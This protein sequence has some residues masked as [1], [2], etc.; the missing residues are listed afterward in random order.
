MKEN[1]CLLP[2]LSLSIGITGHRFIP[3]SEISRINA[4]LGKLLNEISRAAESITL[5]GRLVGLF[6]DQPTLRLVSCLSEGSDR[7]AAKLALANKYTLQAILPFPLGSPGHALDLQGKEKDES[8]QELRQLCGSSE[9]ILQLSPDIPVWLKGKNIWAN[10]EEASAFRQEAFLAASCEMLQFSDLLVAIW[11]GEPQPWQG[12]T[13][14]TILRAIRRGLPVCLISSIKDCPVRVITKEEDLFSAKP[15][16]QSVGDIIQQL[17]GLK[18]EALVSDFQWVKETLSSLE[19]KKPPLLARSWNFFQASLTRKSLK[20]LPTGPY[21]EEHHRIF[22]EFDEAANYCAA[23][24]RSSFLGLALLTVLS[25]IFAATAAVWPSGRTWLVAITILSIAEI[26][27][28]AG[29]I[30]SVVKARRRHWQEKLTTFR[31]VAEVIRLNIF[32]SKIGLISPY[33]FSGMSLYAEDDSRWCTYLLRNCI[34]SM[35]FSSLNMGNGAEVTSLR[36][37]L[38]QYL[39]LSQYFYHIRNQARCQI[40]AKAIERLASILFY[41]SVLVV[42]L[43]IGSTFTVKLPLLDAFLTFVSTIGPALGSA[44]QGIAQTAEL[45]RL[46]IR[47]AHIAKILQTYVT[48]FEH[49]NSGELIQKKTKDVL[50][51]MV[52]DVKDWKEQYSMPSISLS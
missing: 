48:T 49:S 41:T 31:F 35:G 33:R 16:T 47:S 13:F 46:S 19:N 52:L 15:S 12:G 14:D 3:Q 1:F 37:D 30:F 21:R 22:K 32:A 23:M 8:L 24:H 6:T 2:S 28:L 51:L 4:Q 40:M 26:V 43:R 34:R 11:N 44:S 5:H 20:K 25:I 9:S 39:V 36:K 7:I 10:N 17:Y 27:T 42:L 29:A 50:E 18:D 45:K 38:E